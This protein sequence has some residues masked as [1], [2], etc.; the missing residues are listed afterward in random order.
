MTTQNLNAPPLAPAVGTSGVF[1]VTTP[2]MLTENTVYTVS[3][4]RTFQDILNAGQDP[5]A[6]IYAPVG[7]STDNYQTD[8]VA[9]ALIV[10]LSSANAAPVMVPTTYIS[11]VPNGDAVPY[12]LLIGSFQLGPLPDSLD[13]SNLLNQIQELISATLGVDNPGVTLHAIPSSQAVTS[14]Q[15]AAITQGRLAAITNNMSVYARLLKTQQALQD[16]QTQYNGLVQY[17]VTIGAQGNAGSGSG[18]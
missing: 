1:T 18:S 7:L 14:A 4:V 11:Q 2:F 8:L 6:L 15:D 9:G 17:L 3:A 12:S 16:L 13:V 5:V 10:V